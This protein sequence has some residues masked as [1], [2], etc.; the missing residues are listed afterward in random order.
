MVELIAK[1]DACIMNKNSSQ[2]NHAIYSKVYQYLNFIMFSVKFLHS[3]SSSN[4]FVGFLIYYKNSPLHGI[5]Q[6]KRSIYPIHGTQHKIPSFCQTSRNQ[7]TKAAKNI[8]CGAS[9]FIGIRQKTVR[10][11]CSTQPKNDKCLHWLDVH[12]INPY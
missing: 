11:R 10:E 6:D 2:H 8:T 1:N 7:E 3:P 5:H 9:N 12:N 4:I